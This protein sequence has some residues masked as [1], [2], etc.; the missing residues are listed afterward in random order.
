MIL[1]NLMSKG[2]TKPSTNG[3]QQQQS[4]GGNGGTTAPS[5]PQ[6]RMLGQIEKPIGP[7]IDSSKSD[8]FASS[9]TSNQQQQQQ[10]QS[11][12]PAYS[13]KKGKKRK[14][15]H[16]NLDENAAR[17]DIGGI[18]QDEELDFA[19]LLSQHINEESGGGQETR[20]LGGSPTKTKKKKAKKKKV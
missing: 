10:Q 14:V 1:A 18:G 20:G 11:L 9:Q 19:A 12:A 2:R 17:G 3:Q 6:F 13:G 5:P 4:G 7:Y 15:K 16:Y 8:H